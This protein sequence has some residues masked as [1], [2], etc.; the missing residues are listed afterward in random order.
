MPI[1]CLLTLVVAAVTVAQTGGSYDLSKNVVASGGGSSSGSSFTLNGTTAQPAAGT[2]VGK[3]PFSQVG[4]FWQAANNQPTAAPATISGK[5]TTTT[6]APLGGVVIT[7]SGRFSGRTI[8]DTNG[9]YSFENFAGGEFYVATPSLTNYTFTPANRSFTLVANMSDAVFTA[10]A[11]ATPH[12]NP[13]DTPEFFVRQHYLDFLGREPDSSGLNYWTNLINSCPAG[14]QPCVSMLRVATSN[15]FF[16][17]REFQDTG[18]F[19]YRV[20]KASFGT[21]PSFAQFHPDRAAVVGGSNLEQSKIVFANDFVARSAF[22]QKYPRSQTANE[23]VDAL[24]L[25]IKASS[26]V[27]Q[28]SQRDSLVL[29]YDGSDGARAR[30]VQQL[31]EAGS[32][33]DTEYNQAFVLTEYFGFL[34]RDPDRAGYDF[35]LEQVNRFPLRNL[36][37]QQ[38]MVCS[39]LTSTEYQQRFSP[40]VTHSNAE[41]Q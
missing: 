31:A 14:D 22:L 27:D 1:G 30:I 37:I 9:N 26:G 5:V 8:T 2:L 19:V 24:L 18:A 25:T 13:L 17:E 6:G 39:F 41:C 21:N 20:Y 15:A 10:V 35:W 28:G 4:G 33:V 38:A 11:D 29:L 12:G 16:F 32:F 3:P 7:L 40:V 23:F 34:H 36:V